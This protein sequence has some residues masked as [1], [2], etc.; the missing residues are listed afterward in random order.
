PGVRSRAATVL[1]ACGSAGVLPALWRRLQVSEDSRVQ[2]KAWS[3]FLE[4]VTRGTN[5]ELLAEW[6]RRLAAAGQGDRRQAMWA[7]AYNQWQKKEETR[8]EAVIARE[9][10]VQAQLDQGKWA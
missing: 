3:A 7:E 1:G 8:K 6:D 2:E 9:R 5:L 10:L 4:I